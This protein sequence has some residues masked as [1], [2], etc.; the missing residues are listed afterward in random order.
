MTA[1]P[2]YAATIDGRRVLLW[3]AVGAGV[4]AAVLVAVALLPPE[5]VAA[6]G[7]KGAKTAHFVKQEL[8]R[9]HLGKEALHKAKLIVKNGHDIAHLPNGQHITRYQY[10]RL[11][12][13]HGVPVS[14]S[15]FGDA[16]KEYLRIYGEFGRGVLR[17]IRHIGQGRLSGQFPWVPPGAPGAGSGPS[18]PL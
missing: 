3:A 5:H 14:P 15:D 16:L 18:I 2:F 17:I 12:P 8:A 13:T 11:Y 10:T 9:S 4:A 6:A 7:R 1:R